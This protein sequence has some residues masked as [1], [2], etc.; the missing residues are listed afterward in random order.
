MR[1]NFDPELENL[2]GASG[3]LEGSFGQSGKYKIRFRQG[4]PEGIAEALSRKGPAKKTAGDDEESSDLGLT[5]SF[6]KYI[7]SLH[8]KM[9]Q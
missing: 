4:V 2:S 1:L 3:I 6:K 9:I 8:E 5:L 7:Y